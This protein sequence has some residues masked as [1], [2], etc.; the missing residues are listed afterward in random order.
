MEK[1]PEVPSLSEFSTMARRDR[2]R[3]LAD[4]HVARS[5]S[6]DG[7]ELRTKIMELLR[8]YE[9]LHHAVSDGDEGSGIVAFIMPR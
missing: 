1:V 7:S 5:S 8:R 6:P 4:L 3:V 9:E 2:K